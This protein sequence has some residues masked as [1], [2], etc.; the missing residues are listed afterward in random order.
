MLKVTAVMGVL[1]VAGAACCAA[2]IPKI[3]TTEQL[4]AQPATHLQTGWDVRVGRDRSSQ[5]TE[6]IAIAHL[7]APTFT[8][9]RGDSATEPYE[10]L[11]GPMDRC[12]PAVATPRPSAQ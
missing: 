2:E 6:Y 12:V 3:S 10:D 4:Y 9:S 7:P 8:W 1:F 5:L 11:A